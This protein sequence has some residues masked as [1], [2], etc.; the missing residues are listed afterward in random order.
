[1]QSIPR[2]N[3]ISSED[4]QIQGSEGL[5][6]LA[7]LWPWKCPARSFFF[8]DRNS[9]EGTR[10]RPCTYFRSGDL[11]LGAFHLLILQ[12]LSLTIDRGNVFHLLNCCLPGQNVTIFQ[13]AAI[14][15]TY[16]CPIL[17]FSY[18]CMLFRWESRRRQESRD[19]ATILYDRTYLW[20]VGGRIGG[21]G[22]RSWYVYGWY[23][24]LPSPSFLSTLS[25]ADLC[26]LSPAL[27]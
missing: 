2:P 8:S 9:R 11:L 13:T 3:L 10:D 4:I 16:S 27:S 23:A 1:M 7:Y 18:I 15:Y 6:K 25:P 14:I 22:G 19:C 20:A 24:K 12:T 26:S 5:L 17:G 21:E